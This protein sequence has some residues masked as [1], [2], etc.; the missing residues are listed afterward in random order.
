MST[1]TTYPLNGID[2]DAADVAAY[3]STRTSGVYSA[4]EDFAVTAAGGLNVTVGAGRAWIHPSR[5]EGYSVTKRDPET[6]TLPLADGSRPRIDRI[7]LR[8][9][10]AA[11]KTSLL[12]LTGDPASSPTAPAITRTGLTYDLCLA[13]ISRPAGSTAV[14][15]GQITDTRLDESLCGVMSDGVTG[16]PT[17]QLLTEARARI[18]E[19]E[20]TASDSAA[21][22]AA[23]QSAAAQAQA[24]AAAARDKAKESEEAA[25]ISE[26]N[27][28]LS[29]SRAATSEEHS[30]ASEEASKASEEASARSQVAAKASQ[31][32]AATS[33]ANALKYSQEAGAKAGTDKT[34]AIEDAPADAKKT[35]EE[36]ALRY[37]KEL[38]DALLAQHKTDTLLAAYPVGSLYMS[39][40][41][42]SPAGLFGGTW[43]QI[44]DKFILAAGDTY[45]AGSTG[46]EAS[47]TLTINEIPSHGRHLLTNDE[48][49][50]G[51][52]NYVGYLDVAEFTSYGKNGRGW[53]CRAE[54]EMYPAG[55]LVG[56]SRSHNNLPPYT[57]KYI[58]QRI[59]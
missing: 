42:T 59:E 38:V 54:N 34:L 46:G 16:L 41:A 8:Y 35:G 14:T 13:E 17:A 20:E 39:A 43:E 10:A 22:A 21:K 56:G 6:I 51:V 31:D 30:K 53:N 3:E 48:N 9:D 57:T 55:K 12:T 4:D 29:A 5:F 27:A 50:S 18:A 37:T 15:T 36:L 52:G 1:I 40:D 58:W 45:A 32:A 19:V 33:E 44:K 7:I 2:Y 25:K 49:L 47:H 28:G 23:S 26:N 24:D 11:K